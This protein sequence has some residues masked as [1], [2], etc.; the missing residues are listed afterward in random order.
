MFQLKFPRKTRPHRIC[1]GDCTALVT[2]LPQ[3]YV[4]AVHEGKWPLQCLDP[5]PFYMTVRYLYGSKRAGKQAVT[6]AG[7]CRSPRTWK[8]RRWFC[9]CR[10]HVWWPRAG[11]RLPL[12]SPPLATSHALHHARAQSPCPVLLEFIH[13]V[14]IDP[15]ATLNPKSTIALT[16]KSTRRTILCTVAEGQGHFLSAGLRCWV[17]ILEFA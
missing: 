8:R 6:A 11:A 4:T 5:H 1:L 9:G 16:V 7:T 14:I 12:F 15:P 2:A 10:T 13:F 3:V 17:H